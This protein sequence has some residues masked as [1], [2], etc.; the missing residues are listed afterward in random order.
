MENCI[1]VTSLQ[2]NQNRYFPVNLP[3]IFN[4]WLSQAKFTPNEDVVNALKVFCQKSFV[5][6][7]KFENPNDF[8]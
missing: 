8:K 4:I 5:P 7:W 1:R 6:V 3:N 2:P